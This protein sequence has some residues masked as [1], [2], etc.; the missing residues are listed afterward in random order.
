[1]TARDS[2]HD[3]AFPPKRLVKPCT[4]R[5]NV[6]D[7]STAAMASS[8]DALSATFPV[9]RLPPLLAP[10]SLS[11]SQWSRTKAGTI[12]AADVPGH[13]RP[14]TCQPMVRPVSV[15]AVPG[16]PSA[17]CDRCHR[18]NPDVLA[19]R[20][21]PPLV[22]RGPELPRR[23]RTAEVEAAY[24]GSRPGVRHFVTPA[25]QPAV[26]AWVM[27]R[28]RSPGS[29]SWIPEPLPAFAAAPAAADGSGGG[30]GSHWTSERFPESR[31]GSAPVSR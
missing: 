10:V 6:T 4:K 14:H 8:E 1:M 13:V 11:H 24:A 5:G 12:C 27:I 29:R 21:R 23:G 18:E 7:V 19:L 15:V 16:Q 17:R 20:R 30:T 31:A 25:A 2:R 22:P 3:S 9:Q 26:D 28:R